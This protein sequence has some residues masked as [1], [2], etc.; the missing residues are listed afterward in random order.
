MGIRF[1]LTSLDGT[2]GTKG[3]GGLCTERI[4]RCGMR[5]TPYLELRFNM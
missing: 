3:Y 4:V 5:I 2:E 1:L